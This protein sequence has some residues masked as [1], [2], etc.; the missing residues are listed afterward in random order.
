MWSIYCVN[1]FQAS[2][3][4]NL[5]AY[6]LSG[7]QSHSLIPVISVVS[8]IMSGILYLPIAKTLD[9]WGRSEGF[10]I[11]ASI[12]TLGL[13]LMA[14]CHSVTT[15]AAAQGFYSVGFAGMI[16]C[17]D[18]ITSDTSTLRSRGL[19]YAFT[20]SPYIISA[21]A[22]PTAAQSFYEQISWRWA[23]GCFAIILPFVAIPLYI[24]LQLNQ[25]K[26]KRH[27]VMDEERGSRTPLQSLWHY[28]IE[29]DGKTPN[30]INVA[31]SLLTPIQLSVSLSSQPA[32]H[33]SSC[34]SP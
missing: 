20:A 5:T 17:V 22:G 13:I 31:G 14:T 9:I 2:I 3:T 32:S 11:M 15:Y 8:N 33:S 23:F 29:F 34:P 27:G 18:V 4:S 21:F 26:A 30:D 16:Y 1:A 12:A 6:V 10:L 25:R 19:A 28:V 7:F 24:T